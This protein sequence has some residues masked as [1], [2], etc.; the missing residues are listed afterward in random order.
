MNRFFRKVYDLLKNWITSALY[1]SVWFC[2]LTFYSEA[3]LHLEPSAVRGYGFAIFQSVLLAKFLTTASLVLPMESIVKHSVYWAIL[4]RTTGASILVSLLRYFS[5]GL[6]GFFNHKGFLESILNFYQGDFKQAL[7]VFFMYWLI[8]MPYIVYGIL[9]HLAGE[10]DLET[11]LL[12]SR[13]PNE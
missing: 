1:F 9:K 10:K 3:A 8:I 7:A 6:E 2:A 5:V 11:H 13:N 12:A 4:F